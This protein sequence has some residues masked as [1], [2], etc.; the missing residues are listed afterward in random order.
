[1]VAL[2]VVITLL[3][4]IFVVAFILDYKNAL[5]GEKNLAWWISVRDGKKTHPQGQSSLKG[6]DLDQRN[7]PEDKC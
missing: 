2:I 5:R 6:S 7:E 3:L 4:S 1:M